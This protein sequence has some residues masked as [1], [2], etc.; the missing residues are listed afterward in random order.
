MSTTMLATTMKTEASMT[1]AMITGRSSLVTEETAR[2]PSPGSP[3]TFSTT[4]APPKEGAQVDPELGDHRRE[5]GAKAM[6][7]DHPPL[8]QPFGPGGTDVVLTE[9][10]EQ[11][12]AGEALV[13]GGRDQRQSYPRQD[14]VL[15][16]P[17]GVGEQ[18][19][20]TAPGE[21][22]DAGQ[23]ELEEEEE[24]EDQPEQERGHG[25]KDKGGPGRRAVGQRAGVARRQDPG[26]DADDEP[27]DGGAD[28][29]RDRHRGAGRDERRHRL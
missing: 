11:R 20:V 28:G 3:N 2:A 6:A 15:G 8:A 5:G 23:M 18:P 10:I 27:H 29:H 19:D 16:P 14:Q 17:G 13:G 7:I 26:A 24:E 4:M 25:V 1:S 9:H 12:P 21:Q 22:V